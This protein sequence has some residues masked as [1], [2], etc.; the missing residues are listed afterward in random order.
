MVL[1]NEWIDEIL[2]AQSEIVYN[3][4][5]FIFFSTWAEILQRKSLNLIV[6]LRNVVII[7]VVSRTAA[8]SGAKGTYHVVTLCPS[9][10][11]RR[12]WLTNGEG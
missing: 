3:E 5:T 2:Y 9:V 4:S 12:Q 8:A 11:G 1:N 10:S 7:N 6:I